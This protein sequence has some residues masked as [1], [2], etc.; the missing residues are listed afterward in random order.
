MCGLVCNIG[1]FH[2]I[3]DNTG[4]FADRPFPTNGCLVMFGSFVTY[5]TTEVVYKY[6]AQVLV[7]AD[8][9][10]IAAARC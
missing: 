9:P 3:S 8:P 10:A 5:V 4:S 7:A 2:F 1:S 6:P